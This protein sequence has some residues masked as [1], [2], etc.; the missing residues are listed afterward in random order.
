MTVLSQDRTS[1]NPHH[2]APASAS[3]DPLFTAL[4]P[5]EHFS[6]RRLLQ[7]AGFS[8]AALALYSSEFARHNLDIIHRPITLANLPDTFHGFRIVQISDIHLD[9]FTELAFLH[10]ILHRVNQL[11]PDLVLI[12]G[13]YITHG[14]PRDL[15]E[16]TIY[17]CA[18]ALKQIACP[19]RLGVLGNHD[20]VVNA[21]YITRVLQQHGT[22]ILNNRFVPIERDG[23]RIWISGVQDPATSRPNLDLAIPDRPDAPV[24]LMA[25]APDYAD[26]VRRHPKGQD[27]GLILSGHSHGG[28]VRLPIIG[29]MILPP[30]GRKY[31]HGHFHLGPTQLYVNRGLG[32]VGLPFRLNCPPEITV[33]TLNAA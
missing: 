2:S 28:Q 30:M 4:P 12:T 20:S 7:A 18:N 8:A 16:S 27:V 26:D 33:L 23:K 1:P 21:P 22:P 6:R 9:E 25:H 24:I 3:P 13:D 15:P 5:Q 11:A 19:Q 31:V 32:A 29:P 17:T 10:H 14:E